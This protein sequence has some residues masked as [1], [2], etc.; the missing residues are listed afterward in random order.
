MQVEESP[1]MKVCG[2]DMGRLTCIDEAFLLIENGLIKDFG[3]MEQMPALDRNTYIIDAEGGMVFPS[4]CD[5][6]THIVYAGSREIEY[7]DKI[8]GLSYEEIAKRGGGI[9]N[10]AK[11]LHHTSEDELYAQAL[12]RIN[13]I[14]R[15]GTGA[16]EIKSG[17]GLNTED[18]MKMLRVIRRLKTDSP[19]TIKATFL[20]AHAVPAEYKHRQSEY[21]DLIINEMIP[22]IAA[23]E[24]ADYM[25][26]FCEQGFFTIEDTERLLMAGLHYGLLPKIHANQMAYSGGI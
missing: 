11:L 16:V 17:Y 1:R 23:E 15:F 9:L 22:Q 21:V 3:L 12:G 14:M 10:S 19:L 5:S 20:G 6:H 2:A 13:E 18:E 25:D 7:I 4:F 26:V 24:L 8:R